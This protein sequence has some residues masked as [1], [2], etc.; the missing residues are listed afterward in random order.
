M[1]RRF[2]CSFPAA[3]GWRRSNGCSRITALDAPFGGFFQVDRYI[4]DG[5]PARA[6]R[7]ARGHRAAGRGVDR[8]RRHRRSTVRG[9]RVVRRGTDRARRGQ[10]GRRRDLVAA[11]ARPDLGADG[12]ARMVVRL[13]AGLGRRGDAP[14]SCN[15][16]DRSVA[17]ARPGPERPRLR[18][19]R[20]PPGPVDSR[21]VSAQ[22][23]AHGCAQSNE[24]LA[25]GG[26][27]RRGR[28]GRRPAKSERVR[29]AGDSGPAPARAAADRHGARAR[30]PGRPRI[31]PSSRRPRTSCDGCGSVGRRRPS[32]RRH[33]NEVLPRYVVSDRLLARQRRRRRTG[34]DG[35]SRMALNSA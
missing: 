10:R 34:S 35:S 19:Q 26:P 23:S 14:R 20:G 12:M 30:A 18:Q 28:C 1:A 8:R 7:A 16:R 5:R 27:R 11:V 21:L 13:D 15:G 24:P 17:T 6:D 2:A 31:T 25:A 33:P 4:V 9:Y 22:C 32:T 29:G 3:T